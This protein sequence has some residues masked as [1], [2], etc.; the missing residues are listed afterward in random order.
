LNIEKL[1]ESK[2]FFTK[3]FTPNNFCQEREKIQLL[4]RLLDSTGHGL[5]FNPHPMGKKIRI[6]IKFSPPPP[7][8]MDEMEMRRKLYIYIKGCLALLS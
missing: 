6:Q 2:S 7:L 1:H 3:Y 8:I 5:G 4:N